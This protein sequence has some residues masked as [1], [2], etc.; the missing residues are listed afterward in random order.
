MGPITTDP[1]QDSGPILSPDRSSVVYRHTQDKI[2]ELRV[3]AADGT[4]VRPLFATP[5]AGCVTPNRPAWNP[6]HSDLLAIQCVDAA[7]K[8][9]LQIVRLDGQVLRVLD[10]GMGKFDDVAYSP[11]GQTLVFWGT[12]PA[13]GGAV[14]YLIPDDGIG[15]AVQLTK[16]KAGSDADPMFSPDGQEVVFTRTASEGGANNVDVFVIKTDGTDLRRLTDHPGQDQNPNFSPDGTEIVFKSNRTDTDAMGANHLWVM[17][18]DGSNQRQLTPPD[19]SADE[20]GA[21]WGPR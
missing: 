11:D 6:I 18:R 10:P 9:N 14:L 21:A 3:A 7:G 13:G 16:D 4:G 12:D 19:G 1:A 20:A 5:P 15:P 8:S 17:N 2:T